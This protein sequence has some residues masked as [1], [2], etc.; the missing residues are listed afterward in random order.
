[1]LKD[2]HS[3]YM[4][5]NIESMDREVKDRLLQLIDEA[6]QEYKVHKQQ[7]DQL[8]AQGETTNSN[9]LNKQNETVNMRV[10]QNSNIT[11]V[12]KESKEKLQEFE[13]QNSRKDSMRH[14]LEQKLAKLREIEV[15]IELE[16]VKNDN[17]K[18]VS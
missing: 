3:Q 6:S 17:L 11:T 10:Q 18:Q 15:N 16:L 2:F 9:S 5:F 1:M 12:L 7:V 8:L 13:N 14:E 4:N